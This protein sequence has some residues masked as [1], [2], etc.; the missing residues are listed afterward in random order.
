VA[1]LSRPVA[2]PWPPRP[3]GRGEV[4]EHHGHRE[5]GEEIAPVL[6][7]GVGG[8]GGHLVATHVWCLVAMVATCNYT[9]GVG[10]HGGQVR[11]TCIWCWWPW[12]QPATTHLLLVAMVGNSWPCVSGAGGYGGKP[13]TTV[14]VLVAMVGN[15]WPHML[16]GGGH[17][18]NLHPRI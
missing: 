17:G 2:P 18:D 16:G 1:T 8:C 6:R 15:L 12:W 5:R 13:A 7:V 11:A 14:L 10:G 4:W 9:S 3:G